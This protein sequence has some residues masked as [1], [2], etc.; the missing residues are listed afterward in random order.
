SRAEP[1]L[2][3]DLRHLRTGLEESDGVA[4]TGGLVDVAAA[5]LHPD[6]LVAVI[7]FGVKPNTVRAGRWRGEIADL[8]A[9]LK[10][11][12]SHHSFVHEAEDQLGVAAGLPSFG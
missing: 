5:D 9:L 11:V 10:A 12:V 2:E 3:D 6:R 7:G 4:S 1:V 8:H